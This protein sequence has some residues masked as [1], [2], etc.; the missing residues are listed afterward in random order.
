MKELLRKI[1][2]VISNI[3]FWF[4][5]VII[6]VLAGYVVVIK[7]LEKQNKIA[8]VPI[9]F[10]TI[11]TQSMYPTIK[12]GD[13]IITY[14]TKDDIYKI[15]D[16]V[17]YVSHGGATNGVT[18]THRIVEVTKTNGQYFYTTKGDA[19]NTPDFAPVSSNDVIGKYIIKI[20]KAGFIQ[21]F[22]VSSFGWL[23]AIVLPAV[24][25]IIYDII[26]I[27]KKTTLKNLKKTNKFNKEIKINEEAKDDLVK[28]IEEKEM[29]ESV[30]NQVNDAFEDLG[31]SKENNTEEIENLFE[32]DDGVEKKENQDETEIL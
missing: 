24:G 4:L 13:I 16:I 18:I 11:L 32:N 30:E 23:V 5:I 19:N 6:I 17:T 10:Y 2:R 12:A 15:G 26:K 7:V 28:V 9:N 8:E 22:L 20:P 27:V 1:A 29:P 14:Q 21:Q 3:F 25:I 31:I